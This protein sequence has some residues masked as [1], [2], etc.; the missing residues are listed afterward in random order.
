MP[1]AF[2]PQAAPAPVQAPPVSQP[3]AP[4]PED[5]S[6]LP[7]HGADEQ[8]PMTP[9]SATKAPPVTPPPTG[10]GGG[11]GG[12]PSTM[13]DDGSGGYTPAPGSDTTPAQAGGAMGPALVLGGLAALFFL[14]KRPRGHR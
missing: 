1:V 11:G 2:I 9:P 3:P 5:G 4:K 6:A 12:A 14:T 13:I 10:G 7:L 8:P